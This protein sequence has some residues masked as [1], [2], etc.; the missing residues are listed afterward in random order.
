V[1]DVLLTVSGTIP[2][3]IRDAIASGQRP[4]ADY[5]EMSHGFGADIIDHAAARAGTGR[6]GRLV[7]RLAGDDVLLAW[8]CLRRST[9]YR[10]IFTDSERVGYPFAALCRLGRRRT[11]HVMIGHR[12]SP[13]KKVLVHRLLGLR[14]R[15]DHVVVYA[16][17]Q[18]DVATERLGYRADQVTLTPFMV[19]TEFWRRNG[20]EITP[21]P[22]PLICAVGQE[23]RDYP[24][25]AEAVRELDVDVTIA[26]ASPWSR[27]NDSSAGAN[28]PDNV[29]AA[30]FGLFDLRQLYAESS[31]VV[32]PVVKTDFQAG[33]TSI[34]E[35]MSMGLAVICTRTSGQTDTVVDG[36]TGIYVPPGDTAALRTAIERLLRDTDERA[37][38]GANA[39]RWARMHAD[40]GSYVKRLTP[41]VGR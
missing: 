35:A 13:P 31:F 23:L 34:L 22:R 36:E 11:R 39:Q 2:A 38:L 25:L 21:R 14:R 29:T 20:L 24:A 18:R 6:I 1:N 7:A 8:A 37:R 5:F 9:R 30:G 28:L 17:T 27:R 4:R 26:A 33:I 15:I 3:G 12:L 16:S 32:V 10:T 40:I 19:D 41:L